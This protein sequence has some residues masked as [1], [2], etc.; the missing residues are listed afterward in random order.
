MGFYTI[1]I[2]FN[3]AAFNNNTKFSIKRF[4]FVVGQKI[5]SVC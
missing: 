2:N 4:N 3:F 1:V 5:V